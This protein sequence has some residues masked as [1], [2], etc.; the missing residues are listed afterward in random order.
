MMERIDR[1]DRAP[2]SVCETCENTWAWHQNNQ[3]Q[4]PFNDGSIP[5]SETFGKRLPDGTRAMPGSQAVVEAVEPSWPFDPVL[6]QALVN[7]GVIT[8]ED[9]QDAEKQIRM[10]T[11]TLKMAG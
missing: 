8:P 11:N 9:L 4:H 5:A 10:V 7:K 6:R 3:T 2:G 1:S